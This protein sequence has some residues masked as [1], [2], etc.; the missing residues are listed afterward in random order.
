[1]NK[2]AK[3]FIFCFISLIILSFMLVTLPF[4]MLNKYKRE[5]LND[6][7]I[8]NKQVL[9]QKESVAEH[10]YLPLEKD[11]H[12]SKS[13]EVEEKLLSWDF[14]S[15]DGKKY[16]YL[17]FDDGP[18]NIVTDKILSCLREEEIKGTFFVLG[19]MIDKNP[20]GKDIIKK[21]AKDGHAIGNHGYSHNYE[22]LYPNGVVDPNSF[23][24][25]MKKTENI[26]KEILGEEAKFKTIR[27]PGGHCSW[28][29]SLIDP[30]LEAEGYAFIDW[31][32]LNG[33]AEESNIPPDELFTR[34]KETL[35][36]IEGNDDVIVVL[37]HDTD[38]KESTVTALKD[39]IEYLK[40]LGYEFKTLK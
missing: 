17:T 7:K 34:F 6:N 26:L 11:K 19:S 28:D 32:V 18:S 33:D 10:M 24:D 36:E 3:K 9:T 1:M 23:M 12:A 38:V 20:N 31:N 14:Q 5:N 35:D 15:E 13:K 22:K 37:M 40:D 39:I 30:I 27:F 25:D 2:E 8:S 29:T 4:K 21:I 16:V